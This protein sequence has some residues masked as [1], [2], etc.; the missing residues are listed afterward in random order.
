MARTVLTPKVKRIAVFVKEA[1]DG[2]AVAV[3]RPYDIVE[4]DEGT[5]TRDAYLQIF[6]GGGAMAGVEVYDEVR[7]YSN[8]PA[9]DIQTRQAPQ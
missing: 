6:P 1:R 2:H 8:P 3:R 4:F 5:G 9:W 7:T